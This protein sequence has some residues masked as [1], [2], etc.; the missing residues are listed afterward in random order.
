MQMASLA[1]NGAGKGLG[2]EQLLEW[3]REGPVESPRTLGEHLLKRLTEF[4]G[5]RHN[6]DE[7]L[8]VLQRAKASA[9]TLA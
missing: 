8:P 1:E 2:R 9:P 5:N 4:R 7:T 3:A 6:D